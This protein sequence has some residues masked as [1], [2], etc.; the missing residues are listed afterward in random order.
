MTLRRKYTAIRQEY[1]VNIK[2]PVK[3]DV[4]NDLS[5]H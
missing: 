1:L 5:I 4:F 2:F 3:Q